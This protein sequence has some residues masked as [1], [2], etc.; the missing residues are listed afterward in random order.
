MTEQELD[1]YL[2]ELERK[3]IDWKDDTRLTG[4]EREM[5]QDI[6]REYEK[7]AKKLF[8]YQTKEIKTQ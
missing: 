3:V 5:L 7:F 4:K 2:Y 6:I 8:T 1:D